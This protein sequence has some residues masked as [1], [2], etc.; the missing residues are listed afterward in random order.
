MNPSFRSP[1][2]TAL[3]ALLSATVA[4]SACSKDP[5]KVK[6]DAV[7]SGD[8]YVAAK[9]YDQA[10]VE[11]KRALQADPSA[12][13]VRYKLAQVY[14]LIGDGPSALR[15]A[16]RAADT[17]PNDLDAQLQAARILIVAGLFEDGKSRAL[18]AVQI[19]P[20]S[21]DAQILLGNALAGLK[22]LNGAIKTVTDAVSLNQN[23]GLTYV[24]LGTMK[25]AAGDKVAAEQA[26]KRAVEVDPKS[27][28]AHLALG[29]YYWSSG[30]LA[31][32][33]E[34]LKQAATIN[35][36]SQLASRA[37]AAFYI[38]A[39]KPEL[40]EQYLKTLV[41][42]AN[43][44]DA[45]L[46]LAEFYVAIKKNDEARKVF[47]AVQGSSGRLFVPAT[48]GLASI[49]YAAN[50]KEQALQE[51]E[52]ALAREPNNA[53]ARLMKVKYLADAG[54]IAEALKLVNAVVNDY[55]NS[56][57]AFFAQGVVLE[58]AH[59]P[60]EA[61]KAYES[62]HRLDNSMLGAQLAL[63]RLSLAAGDANAAQ[64]YAQQFLVSMPAGLEPRVILAR[65]LAMQG[66]Y[67]GA[68]TQ[69]VPLAKA[70]PNS[71]AVHNALGLTY[72]LKKDYGAAREE[73]TAALKIAPS[74]LEALG[75]LT[76]VDLAEHRTADA[77]ARIEARLKQ[78]PGDAAVQIF[79]GQAYLAMG[80]TKSAE[81]AY[82]KAV[83]LDP[84]RFEPYLVLARM[85]A[86]ENRLD[87]ASAEFG[88]A[89]KRQPTNAGIRTMMGMIYELQKQP[90]QA[91]KSYEAALAIDPRSPVAANNLAQHYA[92]A[93]QN[94]DEALQ[95]AQTAKN[96][97][98]DRP[99]VDDTLGW[100]YYKKGLAPLAI[101][102]FK[103]C[104]AAKPD[105]PTFLAHLGLAYAQ[106][107][108]REP[109]R[110]AL[111]KALAMRA[112]FDGAADAR[113]TLAQLGG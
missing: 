69:L 102:S 98:P 42:K 86:T 45:R 104:V 37:L 9:Q 47:E 38:E 92:D 13:A 105:N 106:N 78:T 6:A 59:Q 51:L 89:A 93:G 20:K 22:D 52:K 34:E 39:R 77:R 70:A 87:D 18:K 40:A 50:K 30:N 80:D 108:D 32:A 44:D 17:L 10:V 15:E 24:N 53:D 74:S 41:D 58:A 75:G 81:A 82:R 4:F 76:T 85:Y 68:L 12:G 91:R 88:E 79:A 26:F 95:L 19:D 62:A 28:G 5:Q 23:Y 112:D 84:S 65:S 83:E 100:V 16:V 109:A 14:T 66:N 33:E 113:A 107:K 11:Y 36:A 7:A 1:R 99:E 57:S 54:N 90:D 111:K 103:L 25:A 61:T 3:V 71:E 64:G 67:T 2:K 73:Y 101:R 110:Q 49:D 43:D 48:L 94:L 72:T 96:G 60:A 55:P 63:A 56:A 8:K 29:N 31:G 21:P 27:E 46:T 35:P 97:L